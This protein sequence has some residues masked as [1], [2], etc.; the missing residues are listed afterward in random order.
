[1]SVECWKIIMKNFI[2]NN[3]IAKFQKNW[4]I[5]LEITR[6]FM[7]EKSPLKHLLNLWK[8]GIVKNMFYKLIAQKSNIIITKRK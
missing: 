4:V 7:N 3:L 5:Y 1:M 6:F 8:R 2:P